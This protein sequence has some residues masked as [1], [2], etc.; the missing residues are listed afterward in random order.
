M[1]EEWKD[2]KENTRFQISNIGRV[3]S[4]NKILSLYT[5]ANNEVVYIPTDDGVIRYIIKDLV[6]EYF[7]LTPKTK[8][9]SSRPSFRGRRKKRRCCGN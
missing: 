2:I 7:N 9:R 4:N 5:I 1:K 8:L 3:R 6:E